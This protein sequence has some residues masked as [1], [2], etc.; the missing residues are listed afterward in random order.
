MVL[1]EPEGLLRIAF[2]DLE[3]AEASSSGPD[4]LFGNWGVTH[5]V[6]IL[7][8]CFPMHSLRAHLSWVGDVR[9]RRCISCAVTSQVP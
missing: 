1:S 3:T 4:M 8:A 5:S 7:S 6:S 2:I 9:W